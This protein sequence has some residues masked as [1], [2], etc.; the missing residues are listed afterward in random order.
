MF[1]SQIAFILILALLT[2]NFSRFFI[3]AG[4]E[5]NRDFI[6]ATL[7]ENIDVPEMH[8]DGQCYLAKKIKQAQEKEKSNS[9]DLKK[10]NYQE[11]FISE[12]TVMTLPFNYILLFKACEMPFD[13]PLQPASI[14][15]PPKA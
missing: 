2:S 14:F 3:Y 15:H 5:L 8:C 1:R 7:C 4:F 13:L 10:G 12:K 9:Q 6:A 11:A